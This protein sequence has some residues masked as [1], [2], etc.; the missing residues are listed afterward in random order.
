MDL[1]LRKRIEAAR[2][3]VEASELSHAHRENLQRQLDHAEKCANGTPDKME[4]LC[5]AIA[6]TLIRDAR[7]E[8]RVREDMKHAAAAAA[9][10]AVR[11]QAQVCAAAA[12]AL[13]AA[14]R[15]RPGLAG[16]WDTMVA[17][18][19]TATILGVYYMVSKGYGADLLRFLERLI[20]P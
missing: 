8:I 17:Q 4:A 9:A 19:P 6:D 11:E 18:S 10:T 5:E 1:Q 7:E 14:R 20:S 16:V 2:V 12:E 3:E 13:A 15:R